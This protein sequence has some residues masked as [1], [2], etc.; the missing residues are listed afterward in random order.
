MLLLTET[1]SDT[2]QS[3]D[4]HTLRRRRRRRAN[5]SR[6]GPASSQAGS[7]SAPGTISTQYLS[8]QREEKVNTPA[9]EE[10][11]SGDAPVGIEDEG[12]VL[13]L[14]V[15]EFLLE[16]DA[17][18]LEACARLLDV[19]DGDGDVT[20]AAAGVLV[21]AGVAL[22]VGVGLGAVVVGELEDAL[23]VEAVLGSCALAVVVG[24]E[25]EGERLERVFCLARG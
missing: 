15:G 17:E 1:P 24:E 9:V 21:S 13:H 3:G 10:T 19:V 4:S 20:E 8:T 12:D 22:E 7:L 11:R 23:A 2:I 16:A 5:I 25:V 18:G 14:A 6:I